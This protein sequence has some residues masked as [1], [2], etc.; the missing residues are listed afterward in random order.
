MS[1]GLWSYAGQVAP[2]W[3]GRNWPLGA[4]WSPESTNFAVYSPHATACWVCVFDEDGAEV[5]HALT[6]RSL[7][8]WHGALPD[9]PP[10]TRYGYR[11]DG[12][13]DPA[14]GM[15]FNPAKLLLD[16]YGQAVSGT[17]DPGQPLFGYRFD[18]PTRRNDDDSAPCTARSV[19]VDPSFDWEGERPMQRRWRDTVV[20]ELH[21]KGFTQ[22][23]DRVPEELRGTYAGLGTPAVTDYL[24][25]LG[26]TA[27]ELLPVHQFFSE[28]GLTARGAAN[29]WGYN[30]IGY[31][32]PHNA[33]SAS[34]DRGEQVTEF[35]QMVKDLHRAGIEVILDVVYNH[36]AE[37]GPMGPT[38]SFRGLDDRGFY[39][40]VAPSAP[41][42]DAAPGPLGPF[43]DTY[44]DVTG[45][46]NTVNSEDPL[47]LRMILDS[48]RYW[49]TEMHVDGFRFDLMSALT[50]TGHRVDMT[51][52]LLVAIGQDPVLRHVKLIAE[53]WDASMDGYLVGAMPPPWVE[54]NDQY[55]DTVR[56]FWRGQ[57][58]GLHAVATRLAGSSDLYADDGRSAYNSVNF[59]TAHDGFTV[60]DLVSYDRKHNE[61]NGEDNRDGTDGNRSWN[62]GVEGETDD[63]RILA[64]RRRQAAN[65]MAT[66]CLSNGVPMITAGDERG[67]TQGGNNNAYCQDNPTSWIDWRPDDAWLDVYDVV[68]TALRLR[69][70]HPALRQRHWFEG[71]PTIRGGPR[72]LAW[73][74]PSGRE[75]RAED[76]H[77]GAQRAV[78]MFVSGAPLRSPGPRGEQQVDSS[79]VLWFNAAHESVK[80]LLPE[81]DWVQ[82]GEVVL[83]TSDEIG[84]GTPLKAGDGIDVRS[85]SVV[86][87]RA[88]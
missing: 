7:G 19:V 46:G 4:T 48:L 81:N 15:R 73:L 79:F 58:P 72:D 57:T 18:D 62:H 60:R 80:V 35:K 75:M 5:R 28:P 88:T 86:V 3:P 87:I 85:R 44:W 33:Y 59:V 71:R 63:E 23:H 22:L 47:A 40:R 70:E 68:K 12:P 1:P 11:V 43:D 55:R 65:L 69:R 31:F 27:V 21:V 41:T 13:W 52:D 50:R 42:S 54:W 8:I 84:V 83:S 66:L 76:W 10:G 53:P 24:N 45:C 56:D 34:G 51:S 2:V 25:D 38:L 29:Y 67:R 30:S 74:H 77:D 37:A 64:R 20:Y 26:V 9:L 14:Q 61:A 49:V 78:G 6:E 39:R 17:I 16:P 82:S 32:A 36:T